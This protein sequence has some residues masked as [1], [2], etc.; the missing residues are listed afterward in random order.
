MS[1]V[2]E[3][4][5]RESIQKIAPELREIRDRNGMILTGHDIKVTLQR[6]YSRLGN[7]AMTVSSEKTMA[8]LVEIACEIL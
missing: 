6:R 5:M 7:D 4:R 2:S 1:K 3:A 8:K